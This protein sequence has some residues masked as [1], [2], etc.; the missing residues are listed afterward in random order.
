MTLPDCIYARSGSPGS[1]P[2]GNTYV[3]LPDEWDCAHEDFPFDMDEIDCSLCPK[4]TPDVQGSIV[5]HREYLAEMK[6]EE[7]LSRLEDEYYAAERG[8]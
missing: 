6:C 8:L 1:V 4:Y 2:Y 7:E 5:Y 3:D